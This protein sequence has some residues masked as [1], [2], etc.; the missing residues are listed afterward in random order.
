[1]HVDHA[2]DLQGFA[3]CGTQHRPN[4]ANCAPAI[5]DVNGDGVKEIVV[6]GDVY[7]C[8]IGEPAG[9]LYHLPLIFNLDRTRWSGQRLRL[10]RDPRRRAGRGPLSQDFDVIENS[11]QNAVVADLDS[12]GFKEILYPSY[13]GGCTPIGW[14]RP[15]TAAGRSTSRAAG[16]RFASEPVVVDIDNDGQAEVIFT[17]W[18]KKAGTR[19]GQLHILSSQGK[20]LHAVDLPARRGGL[21][22]RPGAHRRSPTSTRDADLEMVVGHVASGVV[23]YDLPGTANARVLWGTGRGEPAAHGRGHHAVRIGRRRQHGRRQQRHHG[24]HVHPQPVPRHQPDGHR[25][26]R[27]RQRHR[28][29]TRGLHPQSGSRT[30][31]PGQVTQTVTIPVA[32]DTA[33]EPDETFV[34]NLSAPANATIADGQGVGTIVN[35]D[36]PGLSINDVIGDRRATAAPPNATFTV[37]LSAA[38]AHSR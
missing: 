30:F 8:G 6:P 37:T 34:L 28:H 16:I 17:S 21:E 9:D 7:N 26:L 23:A 12:D 38:S 1:M 25:Q 13:D 20:Q 3:N 15:S 31:A 2:A 18:A 11:V 32:G 10:D 35:D 22:R 29:G 33:V 27:H 4:F 14:T 5:A 24:L 36:L 19:V